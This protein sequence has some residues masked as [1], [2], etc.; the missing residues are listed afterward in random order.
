[1]RLMQLTKCA[2]PVR[3]SASSRGRPTRGETEWALTFL[4]MLPSITASTARRRISAVKC[5]PSQMVETYRLDP[6]SRQSQCDIFY[7]AGHS[8][9]RFVHLVGPASEPK[10]KSLRCSRPP[11]E[12]AVG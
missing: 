8:S 3:A 2:G 6:I 9:S 11:Q 5:V 7:D 1:M 10:C 4:N 12:T